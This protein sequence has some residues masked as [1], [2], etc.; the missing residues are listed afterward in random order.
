MR[1]IY[2]WSEKH[3]E[4]D[5]TVIEYQVVIVMMPMVLVGSFVGVIVNIYL[6]ALVLSSI[7]F[8]LL[9][10]L[11]IQSTGKAASLFKKETVKINEAKE[12]EEKQKEEAKIASETKGDEAPKDGVNKLVVESLVNSDSKK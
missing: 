7:L 1:F 6:P 11:V 9:F 4:K 10:V 2:L 5:S 12:E 3:P 8:L